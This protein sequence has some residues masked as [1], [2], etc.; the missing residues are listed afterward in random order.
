MESTFKE[1]FGLKA[2]E[3]EEILGGVVSPVVPNGPDGPDPDGSCT[4]CS[5][6]CFVCRDC[7]FCSTH[8]ADKIEVTTIVPALCEDPADQAGL[9]T[10]IY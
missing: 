4:A 1:K 3:M 10:P 5:A 2:E 9:D 7:Y 8:F 6:G